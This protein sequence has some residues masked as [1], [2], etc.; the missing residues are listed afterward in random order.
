MPDYGIWFW[1]G[2]DIVGC[3]FTYEIFTGAWLFET[4]LYTD[5]GIL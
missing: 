2:F 4:G 1:K 5:A 3:G